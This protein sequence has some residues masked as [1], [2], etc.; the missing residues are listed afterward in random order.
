MADSSPSERPQSAANASAKAPPR[1]VSWMRRRR[2]SLV[3]SSYRS[4]RLLL[5]GSRSNGGST[6][7]AAI[8]QDSS[9]MREAI[10]FDDEY[11]TLTSTADPRERIN[12]GRMWQA[13]VEG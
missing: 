2:V 11:G 8:P 10:T 6:C 12:G 9:R 5:I 13:G 3:C 1:L 4:G 7:P